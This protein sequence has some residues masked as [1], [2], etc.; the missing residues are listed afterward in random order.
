M[1]VVAAAGTEEGAAAGMVAGMLAVEVAVFGAAA[2]GLV[3]I[4]AAGV[5]AAAGMGA[6]VEVVMPGALG[7]G[8]CALAGLVAAATAPVIA[9]RPAETSPRAILAR[10]V[11]VPVEPSQEAADVTAPIRSSGGTG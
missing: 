8:A 7:P 2:G 11:R 6:T 1:A 4:A 3:D 9:A 10:R 5:L